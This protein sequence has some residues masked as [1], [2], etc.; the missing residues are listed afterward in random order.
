MNG[1][2]ASASLFSALCVSATSS[3]TLSFVGSVALSVPIVFRRSAKPNRSAVF[4]A[5]ESFSR[6]VAA[7]HAARAGAQAPSLD[8]RSSPCS[9]RALTVEAGRDLDRLGHLA[10]RVADAHDAG[11]RRAVEAA[12]VAEDPRRVERAL[13]AVQL[14]EPGCGGCV[15][16]PSSNSTLWKPPR[17]SSR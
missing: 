15:N 7:V 1:R 13:D 17:G 4:G 16:E 12:V 3:A 11:H 10:G 2:S 9:S 8:R 6:H 14:D 5:S